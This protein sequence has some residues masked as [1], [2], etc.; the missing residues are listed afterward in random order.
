MAGRS[1]PIGGLLRHSS[2]I[3]GRERGRGL[4]SPL[5]GRDRES[6]ERQRRQARES[7]K[8]HWFSSLF[9]IARD[10]AISSHWIENAPRSWPW[11]KPVALSSG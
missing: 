2:S 10:K 5:Y 9:L 6:R 1:I 8:S 3:P 4:G 7:C 11:A